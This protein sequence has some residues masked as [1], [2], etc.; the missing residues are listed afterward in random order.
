MKSLNRRTFLRNAGV[1]LALP[2]LDAMIPVGQS[3]SRAFALAREQAAKRLVCVGNP[4]GMIP[5]RF[6]PTGSGA[7]YTLP[8]T[9]AITISTSGRFYDLLQPGPRRNRRTPHRAYILE[10]HPHQRREN[11]ARRQHQHRSKSRGI[12]GRQHAVPLV[13]CKHQW[14]LRNGLDAHGRARAAN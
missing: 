2:F 5:E 7:N 10:R 8:L 14:P 4:F 6:F 3:A 12:C 9:P 11:D 1:C 13:K